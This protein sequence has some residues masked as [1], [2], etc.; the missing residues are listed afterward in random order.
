[1][2]Y[3]S[4]TSVILALVLILLSGCST[5][6]KK[7]IKNELSIILDSSFKEIENDSAFAFYSSSD[8]SVV[9]TKEDFSKLENGAQIS[10]ERYAELIIENNPDYNATLVCEN[11]FYFLEYENKADR[12]NF[13]YNSYL[14]KGEDAFYTVH[15]AKASK[16][17]NQNSKDIFNEW[18]KTVVITKPFVK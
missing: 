2:K 1:M 12:K 10:I 5:E 3:R 7:F 6:P 17:D 4:F 15:F 13:Y 8:C 14:F 16:K 11:G 9:C 18:A